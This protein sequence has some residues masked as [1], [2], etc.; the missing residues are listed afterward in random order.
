[1]NRRTSIYSSLESA[2]VACYAACMRHIVRVRRIGCGFRSLALGG[3]GRSAGKVL[4]Q[5]RAI[6]ICCNGMAVRMITGL[7]GFSHEWMPTEPG[8]EPKTRPTALIESARC[9]TVASPEIVLCET[10]SGYNKQ[11]RS[12]L[13]F[14]KRPYIR[15]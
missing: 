3:N 8:K 1:M 7:E 4:T 2:D 10:R 14:S 11:C 12:E 15:V 5:Y 13:A 9:L 6:G